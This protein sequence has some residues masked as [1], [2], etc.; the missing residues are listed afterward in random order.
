MNDQPKMKRPI[1]DWVTLAFIAIMLWIILP[2]LAKADELPKMES[3]AHNYQQLVMGK[4]QENQI[5]KA[6]KGTYLHYLMKFGIIANKIQT[7]RVY[8]IHKRWK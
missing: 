1:W 4:E 7:G 2:E 3:Q 6:Y 8:I 5:L